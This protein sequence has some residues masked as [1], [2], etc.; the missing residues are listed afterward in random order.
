MTNLLVFILGTALALNAAG[1][2][3]QD[4]EPQLKKRLAAGIGAD[5][6]L[7]VRLQTTENDK[8]TLTVTLADWETD[9]MTVPEVVVAVHDLDAWSRRAPS[10]NPPPTEITFRIVLDEDA[11]T[12]ALVYFN[13]G[14]MVE[15]AEIAPDRVSVHGLLDVGLGYPVSFSLD[16]APRVHD[17][18]LL[19]LKPRRVSI[20]RLALPRSFARFIEGTLNTVLDLEELDLDYFVAGEADEYLNLE[21]LATIEKCRLA[22]ERLVITGAFKT[23]RRSKTKSARGTS[24]PP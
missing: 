13:P 10:R 22:R 20:F 21:F 15:S 19:L 17:K 11:L 6:R 2:P 7:T 14:V 18:T 3:L 5:A 4:V 9:V 23:P 16:G 1:T 12:E 8:T 24:P